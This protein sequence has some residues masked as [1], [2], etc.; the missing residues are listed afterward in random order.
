MTDGNGNHQNQ[1]IISPSVREFTD[2]L[3]KMLSLDEKVSEIFRNGTAEQKLEQI[4]IQSDLL[5]E[6]NGKFILLNANMPLKDLL[7]FKR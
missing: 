3:A 7:D 5:L 6:P 2:D 1:V 4:L